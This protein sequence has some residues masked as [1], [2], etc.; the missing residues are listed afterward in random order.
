MLIT[1]HCYVCNR[2]VW[3]CCMDGGLKNAKSCLLRP[4][5]L[6]QMQQGR[7]PKAFQRP[8]QETAH[9]GC[10]DHKTCE[11]DAADRDGWRSDINNASRRFEV[12]RREAAEEKCRGRKESAA[13][14]VPA[15]QDVPCPRCS[16]PCKSRIGLFMPTSLPL[17]FICEELPSS[18]STG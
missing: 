7:S 9:L 11:K 14:Q 12:D 15:G 16:R 13:T 3:T 2:L 17:I 4:I 5:T 10:I 8:V 1:C 6:R 18:S